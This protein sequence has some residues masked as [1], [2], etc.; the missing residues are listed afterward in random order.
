MVFVPFTTIDNHCHSV[1]VGAV[2]LA[3]E[4]IESYTWLLQMLLKSFGS[5]SKVVVTDQDPTMKQAIASVFRNTRYRSCMWHIMKKVADKVGADLCN[6]EDFKCRIC[7]I[8]W[9]DS[10]S[11]FEFEE[12]WQSIMVEF[13]LDKNKWLTDMFEIRLD[14]I[15]TFYREEPL[16]GLMHTTSRSES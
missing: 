15:P 10:I 11:P 2:L 5:A 1:I 6:N 13:E 14:W 4:T 3:F 16:S 12:K 9:T 7:D 8:V